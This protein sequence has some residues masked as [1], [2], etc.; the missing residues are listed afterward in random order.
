MKRSI[1]L[2]IL[3]VLPLL[4]VGCLTPVRNE[5]PLVRGGWSAMAGNTNETRLVI[6]NNSNYLLYGLDG[7]GRINV[8]LNGRGVAQIKVGYYAQVMMPKGACRVNLVHRDREDYATEHEVELTGPE[9]FLEI[10]AI[11]FSN[12]AKIVSTLPDDFENKFKPVP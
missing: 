2:A 10:G 4:F 3:S 5:I 6:F 12:R 11:S 9:T 7:S 8:R 1:Q